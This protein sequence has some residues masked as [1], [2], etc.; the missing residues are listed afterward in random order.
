MDRKRE[1]AVARGSENRQ[2]EAVPKERAGRARGVLLQADVADRESSA[3]LTPR[4]RT[5]IALEGA[6]AFV[7]AIA[8]LIDAAT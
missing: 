8:L 5:V 7:C 4:G 3:R 1:V 2:A 6:V